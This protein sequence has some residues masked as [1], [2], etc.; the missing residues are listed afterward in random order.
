[1][2]QGAALLCV[3]AHETLRPSVPKRITAAGVQVHQTDNFTLV[4]TMNAAVLHL[5]CV[6]FREL[7][8]QGPIMQK[9]VP[10]FSPFEA[11]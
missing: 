3:P 10:P 2:L 8:V 1:M 11:A 7:P 4:G 5:I 6:R 9:D